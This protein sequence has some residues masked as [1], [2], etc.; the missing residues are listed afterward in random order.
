MSCVTNA[1]RRRD[2]LDARDGSE[3]RACRR[4]PLLASARTKTVVVPEGRRFR[5]GRVRLL[6]RLQQPRPALPVR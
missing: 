2:A 5:V 1:T 6:C 3:A 4:S